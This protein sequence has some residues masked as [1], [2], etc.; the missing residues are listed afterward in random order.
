[1][2][3]IIVSEIFGPTIQGEGLLI[4]KP[5]VFVRTGGCD[6]RCS[7]C[8]SLHA[9]LP[10]Y[11][12]EWRTLSHQQIFE[13]I[14]ALSPNPILI[15]LSGGNPAIQPLGDL[16][17]LGHK[18]HYVFSMETQGSVPR[19]WMEDL[20]YLILSP[21]PPSSGEKP[22]FDRLEMCL[23]LNAVRIFKI[24]IFDDED[25]NFAKE[26][27]RLYPSVPLVLSVGNP[28]PP[29]HGKFDLQTVIN[30]Y[31]WLLNKVIADKWNKVTV[32]PQLHT[33]VWGNRKGV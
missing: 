31:E 4:G 10:E 28:N 8:D 19:P 21:K 22:R 15:T 9:V 27:Y 30:K 11:K 17:E 18:H 1:M 3:N 12:E 13:E 24:V 16:I 26:I 2:S 20:D 6:Y 33:Y 14:Q 7:W 23:A 29:N 25:Y 5:T 32:L